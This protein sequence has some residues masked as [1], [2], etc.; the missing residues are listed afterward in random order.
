[1]RISTARWRTSRWSIL[2]V[3][4]GLEQCWRK[5][6]GDS[7]AN[8]SQQ[9]TALPQPPQVQRSV[10]EASGGDVVQQ[11]L[12]AE[13]GRNHGTDQNFS[14]T[15]NVFAASVIDCF[16][17]FVSEPKYSLFAGDVERTCLN[18]RRRIVGC[19]DVYVRKLKSDRSNRIHL[20]LLSSSSAFL[21]LGGVY[22]INIPVE[23]D[24]NA[25]QVT[26]SL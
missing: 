10:V 26:D 11:S 17:R 24:V 9:K 23:D 6:R 5:S 20:Y 21:P 19:L 1:M 25:F 14:G 4:H 2:S 15:L 8:P 16:K 18:V 22:Q 13:L 7:S 12:A 3:A